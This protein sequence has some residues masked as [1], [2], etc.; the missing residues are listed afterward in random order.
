MAI[1]IFFFKKE[2]MRQEQSIN[3]SNKNSYIVNLCKDYKNGKNNPFF[4]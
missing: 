3:K 4:Y 2:Y 1:L